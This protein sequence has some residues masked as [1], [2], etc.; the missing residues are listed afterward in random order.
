[1]NVAG[2]LGLKLESL[3]RILDSAKSNLTQRRVIAPDVSGEDH[4]VTGV[5]PAPT[6][7]FIALISGAI[8]VRKDD[9]RK[10]AGDVAWVIDLDRNL[11]VPRPVMQVELCS[12]GG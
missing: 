11:T 5:R 12:E 8:A 7:I 10:R 9:E 2:P 3:G 1:M 6:Q 4:D